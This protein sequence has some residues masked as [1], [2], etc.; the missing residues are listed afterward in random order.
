M[1]IIDIDKLLKDPSTYFKSPKEVCEEETLTRDQKIK[2]LRQWEYDALE[3]EVAEEENMSGGSPDVLHEI[4]VALRKLGASHD[5][6][7]SAPTKQH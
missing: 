4:L 5:S 3:L 7:H 1:N 2:I 6:E